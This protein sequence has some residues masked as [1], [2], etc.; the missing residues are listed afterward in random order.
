MRGSSH[1]EAH[2]DREGDGRRITIGHLYP[3]L[4]NLYGDRG[5]IQCLMK[6]CQWRGIE[7]RTIAFELNDRIDFSGLDI[8]LLGGGSDREQM[9]VCEKLKEIREDFQEYVE[10]DGVVIAICGGY[11]LLGN[12]YKTA[13]GTITGLG[14]V[15]FYTQQG[16]GR[17]IDNI[18][19]KS[20]LFDMPVVGFENHGGRTYIGKN[21]PLGKVLY[22]SGNDGDSGYEGVVYKNVIG[23]Y[24]HGP[25]LPKN[26]QLA[27]WLIARA[28]ERKYGGEIRLSPLDDREEREANDYIYHFCL[29]GAGE[30]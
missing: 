8:V 12:Y 13:Q 26:P 16:E 19:L 7:A 2:A 22:G 6:R 25:L 3:D 24:L 17:L 11:Q 29:R 23:T 5:N 20:D 18:V 9:L 28:L 4:L 30:L 27:D 15:D 10:S 21:R 1:G 14:L